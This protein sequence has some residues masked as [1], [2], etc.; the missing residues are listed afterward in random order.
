MLV[1]DDLSG[2]ADEGTDALAAGGVELDPKERRAHLHAGMPRP[3]GAKKGSP[4]SL[5]VQFGLRLRDV[6]EK[7][8]ISQERFAH[9]CGLDRTYVGS[10]ERGKKNPSLVTIVRI[11]AGLG[12]DPAELVRG[13]TPDD[14]GPGPS[15]RSGRTARP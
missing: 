7:T 15:T 11:A 3:T 9:L 10:I 2:V 13:M 6:W 8:G 4:P 5:P 1:V 12:I 14:N